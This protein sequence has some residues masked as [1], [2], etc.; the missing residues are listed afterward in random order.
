[1]ICRGRS[2]RQRHEAKA[3]ALAL[4][5][6]QDPSPDDGM[7]PLTD[8][9]RILP[10]LD[11]AISELPAGQR[12]AIIERY[13][14]GGTF[15]EVAGR[16][17]IS[18]DAAKKRVTSGLDRLRRRLGGPS[19]EL[20]VA[21]LTSVAAPAW[22][23]DKSGA[24]P[25]ARLSHPVTVHATRLADKVLHMQFLQILLRSLLST[26]MLV[27]LLVIGGFTWRVR[28]AETAE[29]PARQSVQTHMWIYDVRDLVRGERWWW[30]AP[31]T[32]GIGPDPGPAAV[33][34]DAVTLEAVRSCPVMIRQLQR[35]LAAASP[36][37][38]TVNL[39]YSGMT[40]ADL[41]AMIVPFAS[42]TDEFTSA[43]EDLRT[44]SSI[45]FNPVP[46]ATEGSWALVVLTTWA[47]HQR[48]EAVL[49]GARLLRSWPPGRSDQDWQDQAAA[50]LQGIWRRLD[51]APL[52]LQET[53]PEMGVPATLATA[54]GPLL[55]LVYLHEVPH[56]AGEPMQP[57]VVAGGAA[58]PGSLALFTDGSVMWRPSQRLYDWATRVR[59]GVD[60]G[61][62]PPPLTSDLL[63][64]LHWP[65]P[66]APV[67]ARRAGQGF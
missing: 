20:A 63:R 32:R 4:A 30:H 26:L 45:G 48:L 16:L 5:T 37:P 19:G 61:Q 56:V 52:G 42:R 34:Q 47:G 41:I 23:P 43:L 40:D 59:L 13:L 51:A 65:L 60:A 21:T 57:L 29:P 54:T 53:W 2:R 14:T 7:D 6:P 28:A 11:Q 46:D 39:L 36:V 62:I 1:M 3:A 35:I 49:R 27:V 18:A 12:A 24:H 15:A 25:F 10:H 8:L 38:S 17:G 64:D 31:F 55:H 44:E 22:P 9:D 50:A 33:D 66:R 58:S 67:A